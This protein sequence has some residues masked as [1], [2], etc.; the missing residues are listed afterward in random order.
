[1]APA[2]GTRLIAEVNSKARADAI[3]KKIET[4]LGT[5][6]R[7][8]ASEIQSLEKMLADRRADGSARGGA[9]S[10][11]SKQLAELPE[12]REKMKAPPSPGR[13]GGMP[14]VGKG[15]NG[16]RRD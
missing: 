10:K 9:A 15:S 12:V 11:E 4:A 2:D 16:R 13:C 14:T 3:R 8:R 7:Y 1:L 6:I 5:G